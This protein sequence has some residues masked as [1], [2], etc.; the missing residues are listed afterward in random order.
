M[1]QTR[2]P[3]DRVYGVSA[4]LAAFHA[5]PDDVARVAHT[6]ELRF[7]LRETLREAAKRRIAYREVEADE[8][9]RMC[10]SEHHEG[11]CVWLRR[12]R[13]RSLA[14]AIDAVGELGAILALDSVDNPHNVG[15]IV[16][17]AAYFGIA[18]VLVQTEGGR[19]LPASALR[20]AEGGTEQVCVVVGSSLPIALRELRRVGFQIIGADARGGEPL[21]A[22]RFADRSVVVLGNERHGLSEDVHALCHDIV[23]IPGAEAIDSLNV[24]VAAGIVAYELHMNLTRDL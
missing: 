9:S 4:A 6:K 14:D 17:T 7:E 10:E 13:E 5:R 3:L 2:D 19:S 24:S 18:A 20:V 23:V 21:G 12:G 1:T 22:Q 11:V 8:L 15:A 16:R